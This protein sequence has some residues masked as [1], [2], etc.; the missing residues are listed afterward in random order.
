MPD[1]QP[2]QKQDSVAGVFVEIWIKFSEELV[3]RTPLDGC[4][5]NLTNKKLQLCQ[6]RCPCVFDVDF[7][8]F[9]FLLVTHT[10]KLQHAKQT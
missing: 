7:R 1:Q 3:Y 9:L 2:Y 4:F 10:L 5:Q 8:D 6:R